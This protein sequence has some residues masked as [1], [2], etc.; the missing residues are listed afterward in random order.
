M[1][2]GPAGVQPAP[3]HEL[4]PSRYL[5]P[6]LAAPVNVR[7]RLHWRRELSRLNAGD[8]G[9][10]VCPG[11][12]C[13]TVAFVPY[14]CARRAPGE[15]ADSVRYLIA[16]GALFGIGYALG[17]RAQA[18]VVPVLA[19]CGLT[20]AFGFCGSRLYVRLGVLI[21]EPSGFQGIIFTPRHGRLPWPAGRRRA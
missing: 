6:V 15:L 8:F 16:L 5:S 7:S 13:A 4:K 19:A 17:Y 18:G 12:A 9:V 1:H 10:P 21:R 2:P 3:W 11:V 20:T 14:S